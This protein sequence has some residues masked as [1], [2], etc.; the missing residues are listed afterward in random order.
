MQ[1]DE[2]ERHV[3][4]AV[5]ELNELRGPGEQVPHELDARLIGAGGALDS[6]ALVHLVVALEQRLQDAYDVAVTLADERAFSRTKSP[7]RTLG[8]LVEY[9]TELVGESARG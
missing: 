7:F 9:A 4:A 2:I 5:D 8:S 3:L 1:R 6:L